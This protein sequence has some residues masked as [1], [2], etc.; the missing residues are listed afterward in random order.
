MSSFGELV[1]AVGR[2]VGRPDSVYAAHIKEA[3]NAALAQYTREFSTPFTRRRLTLVTTGRTEEALPQVVD[4]PVALYD[5]YGN[6]LSCRPRD[7]EYQYSG[8]PCWWSIAGVFPVKRHPEGALTIVSDSASDARV[9]T[10][11]GLLNGEPVRAELTLNGTYVQSVTSSFDE[12]HDFSV[13]S[14]RDATVV[15]ADSETIGVIGPYQTASRYVW[16]RLNPVPPSGT[17]LT[18]VYIPCVVELV[19]DSDAV[20]S[21]V[22]RDYVYWSAVQQLAADLDRGGLLQVA[23]QEL[24]RIVRGEAAK[25]NAYGDHDGWITPSPEGTF[26]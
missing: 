21:F 18:V 2:Y 23:T 5:A 10:L 13:A 22:P 14:K 3:I 11:R 8:D 25:E 20:P 15:L 7:V 9:V 24:M 6:P 17:E 1:T 4:R 16:I 19:D 12:I 26:E